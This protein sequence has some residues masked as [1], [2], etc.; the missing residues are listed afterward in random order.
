MTAPFADIAVALSIEARELALKAED[1]EH[2]SAAIG[3][4]ETTREH[5]IAER[6]RQAELIGDAYR[7]IR[8]LMPLENTIKAVIE[9][10]GA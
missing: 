4:F 3:L 2:V 6:K 7:V 8:A 5:V 10:G 1:A 9:E